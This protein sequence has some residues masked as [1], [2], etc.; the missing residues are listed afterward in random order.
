M[1]THQQWLNSISHKFSHGIDSL[2]E[3]AV[4]ILS[5]IFFLDL[6]VETGLKCVGLVTTHSLLGT[7]NILQFFDD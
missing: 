6:F 7:P 2:A 4:M 1:P 5:G 3:L